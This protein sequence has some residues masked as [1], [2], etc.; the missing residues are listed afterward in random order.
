MVRRLLLPVGVI[1]LCLA[2][3]D[4]GCVPRSCQQ[5][6]MES[7]RLARFRLEECRKMGAGD[8]ESDSLEAAVKL[9]EEIEGLLAAGRWTSAAGSVARL[10]ESVTKL[11][12]AMKSWD[13]DGDGLSNYAE[14]MLYGTSWNNPDTD[15]DGYGDG[16]EILRYETD[17]LD[18]CSVP[19]GVAPELP[20]VQRCPA[21]EGSKP[22]QGQQDK[23]AEKR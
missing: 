4:A 14:F 22:D 9:S 2:L 7:Y 15:G 18:P 16:T 12:Q 3:A 20:V 21:L 17:P 6:L 5:Q 10:E 13:A 11:T 1:F 8:L 23:H 19:T